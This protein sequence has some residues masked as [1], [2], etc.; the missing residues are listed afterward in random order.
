MPEVSDLAAKQSTESKMVSV[1]NYDTWTARRVQGQ[2]AN[3]KEKPTTPKPMSATERKFIPSQENKNINK[4][5]KT[6][7]VITSHN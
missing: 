2:Q 6:T 5:T 3:N 1:A 4:K 7:T